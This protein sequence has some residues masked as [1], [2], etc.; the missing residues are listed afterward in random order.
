MSFDSKNKNKNFYHS[1]NIFQRNNFFELDDERLDYI[2]QGFSNHIFSMY[3]IEYSPFEVSFFPRSL[4]KIV[5]NN[6]AKAVSKKIN[7]KERIKLDYLKHMNKVYS[8]IIDT[9]NKV[10]NKISNAKVQIMDRGYK[11]CFS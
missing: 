11:I 1:N 5:T 9:Y 2:S 8:S 7:F 10:S 3:N 6:R 4:E